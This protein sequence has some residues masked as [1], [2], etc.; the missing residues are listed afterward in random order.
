MILMRRSS[1]HF[2]PSLSTVSQSSSLVKHAASKSTSS[3]QPV[4]A[5]RR[6]D[7]WVIINA[8]KKRFGNI[9]WARHPECGCPFLNSKEVSEEYSNLFSRLIAWFVNRSIDW[10]TVRLF[11]WLIDWRLADWLIDWLFAWSID[12]LIKGWLVFLRFCWTKEEL[13]IDC[14]P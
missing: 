7:Q 2:R 1:G 11:A 12:W 14:R 10:L 9:Q 4:M 3:S 5:I 13:V 8:C 6:E